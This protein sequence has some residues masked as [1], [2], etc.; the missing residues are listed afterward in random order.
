MFWLSIYSD[1]ERIVS[2]CAPCHALKPHQM[3]EPLHLH[4]I[5]DLPWTTT[6]ANIFEWQG[7]EHLVLVDSF[8][9]WF[10]IDHLPNLTS[11]MVIAKLKRH[12]S[13]HGI[14]Y[15][16]LTDN[17]R[18]FT[19]KEFQDFATAWDFH[20]ITSSPLYPQ[21]NG[22]AERA[23]RSAKHLLEKC[24]HDG[25]DF[26]AAL[27]STRNLPRDGLPLPAQRLLS[28]RTPTMMPVIK[29]ML[30]P[31]VVSHAHAALVKARQVRKVYYDKSAQTLPPLHDGQTVRIQTPCGHDKLAVVMG[32]ASQPNSY[33]VQVQGSEYVRNR[34]HL[35]HTA[36]DYD[37]PGK[38]SWAP[39]THDLQSEPSAS[40]DEGHIPTVPSC[41]PGSP[42]SQK[43]H[44]EAQTSGGQ[45]PFTTR[46]G[47]VPK[48]NPRYADL[49][50]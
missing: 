14:P 44:A 8:S 31:K 49:V 29:S 48:P 38:P 7:K 34:R 3:R 15:K 36:E 11:T 46:S 50:R 30:Q 20:H 2:Q 42:E 37:D 35:L 24:A 32:K 47:K 28:R 40:S 41:W 1:I 16:L 4:D 33:R 13:V 18:Q 26:Y 43:D 12:F 5:P 22:L 19:S 10:E 21:S 27:L 45:A 6:A 17:A 39:P 25:T 23:V 9:G